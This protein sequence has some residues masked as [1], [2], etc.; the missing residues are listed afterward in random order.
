MDYSTLFADLG[1]LVKNINLF[2]SD[3]SEVDTRR[4][5]IATQFESSSQQTSIKNLYSIA[6]SA[7]SSL[8]SV[9]SQLAAM[10]TLRLQDNDTVLA[11]LNLPTNSIESVLSALIDDMAGEIDQRRKRDRSY[12][13]S[14]RRRH[15]A[16][17]RDPREDRLR[18]P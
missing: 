7:K 11:V 14:A 16:E 12:L 18:R 5:E 4:D 10:A 15:A 13:Q 2:A 8:A 9:Q 3:A 1:K 6:D 17:Q